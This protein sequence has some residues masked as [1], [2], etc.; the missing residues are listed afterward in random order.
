L[1]KLEKNYENYENFG[2]KIVLN[3]HTKQSVV[4]IIIEEGQCI[5]Q[6]TDLGSNADLIQNDTLILKRIECGIKLFEKEKNV[7]KVQIDEF[8]P[9]TMTD[10][11]STPPNKPN[12]ITSVDII[13]TFIDNELKIEHFDKTQTNK[14]SSNFI[15]KNEKNEKNNKK[16]LTEI[17]PTRTTTP[18]PPKPNPPQR[19]IR[20]VSNLDKP[21][22]ECFD[23]DPFS[24]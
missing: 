14:I 2:E 10:I 4:D 19:T 20:I 22:S 21:Q 12:P 11:I 16:N 24:M 9:I 13:D 8:T 3:S 7:E 18:P 23:H 17:E 6:S 15:V 5:A 1:D